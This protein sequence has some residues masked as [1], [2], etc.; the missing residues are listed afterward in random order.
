MGYVL[1]EEE[2]DKRETRN[3]K[4][5]TGKNGAVTHDKARVRIRVPLF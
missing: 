2:G 3:G 1:L 4:R 5:E